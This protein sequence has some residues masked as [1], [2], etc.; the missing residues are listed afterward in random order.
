MGAPEFV[1]YASC[2]AAMLMGHYLLKDLGLSI[3]K[4]DH[5]S[6]ERAR[7]LIEA[8]GEAYFDRA[9]VTLG[10]ALTALY[11]GQSLSLQRLAATF[12]RGDLMTYLRPQRLGGQ[13]A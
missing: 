2:F 1:R 6:F 4:L 13:P 10:E 5:R 12:R 3:E 8:S 7:G 11:G 9:V